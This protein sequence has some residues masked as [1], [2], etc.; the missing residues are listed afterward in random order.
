MWYKNGSVL[1]FS[2]RIEAFDKLE[3]VVIRDAIPL[4]SGA[5][6]C[7]VGPDGLFSEIVHIKINGLFY[8]YL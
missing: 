1:T 8:R 4:D 2:T 3:R 6:A 5:Y 7:A